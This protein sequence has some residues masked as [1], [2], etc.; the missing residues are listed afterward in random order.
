VTRRPKSRLPPKLP[1]PARDRSPAPPKQPTRSERL[2]DAHVAGRSARFAREDVVRVMRALVRGDHHARLGLPPFVDLT[3]DH[4]AAAAALI[5]GWDGDGPRAR[6]DPARTIGGFNAACARVLEVARGGGR[7]AFATA[8]PASLL[9]L[10]RALAAAASAAG[11]NV[12]DATQSAPIDARGH[13][14]WWIDGV[15]I[16]TD[17]ESLLA[18]HSSTA[19]EELLFVLPRPDLVVADHSFAGTAAGVGLEVVA[20]ADLDA[21]ALAVASWRGMAVRVVPLDERRAPQAYAPLLELLDEAVR[22]AVP[23]PVSPDFA[24][25]SDDGRSRSGP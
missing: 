8:Y 21:I 11:G 9:G 5:F 16:V 25:P 19:A 18:D 14:L 12:L 17:G 2:K 22:A 15:A 6:I 13:R 4:A 1:D 20:F 23:D 3:V 10:H 7:L 24:R